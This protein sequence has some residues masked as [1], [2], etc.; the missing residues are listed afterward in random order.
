LLP[1]NSEVVKLL[2]PQNWNDRLCNMGLDARWCNGMRATESD[3]DLE[4][5]EAILLR[6]WTTSL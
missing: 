2:I 6:L 3:A 1:V 4:E 5:S